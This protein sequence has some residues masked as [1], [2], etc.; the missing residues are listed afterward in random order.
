DAGLTDQHRVVLLAARQHLDDALDLLLAP[1]HRVELAL[2]GELG[3]VAAELVERRGLGALLA[4]RA[5]GRRRRAAEQ[6]ERLL[7]DPLAVDAQLEQDLGGDALPLA[8][9]AEQ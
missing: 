6:L 8:D 7:A 3:E 2:A 4:L 5:A 9:Q 1:D